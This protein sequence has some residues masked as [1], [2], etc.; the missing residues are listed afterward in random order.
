LGV[1]PNVC[2]SDRIR[3]ARRLANV[4]QASLASRVGV[5]SSAV[6]QW[7]LAHG[8]T[9]TVDHLAA[10]ACCCAVRFEWLATGRGEVRE[11]LPRRDSV[12]ALVM[13]ETDAEG[14]LLLAFRRMSEA[15]R[16]AL[17]RLIQVD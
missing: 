12:D 1:D 9:P 4:S 10:I 15:R 13:A 3:R 6:A 7:E 17:L 8:T 2:L 16:L 14:V 5:G 11:P